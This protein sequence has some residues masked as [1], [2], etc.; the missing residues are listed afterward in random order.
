LDYQAQ[1]N[2]QGHCRKVHHLL[3]TV[4]KTPRS[5]NGPSTKFASSSWISPI[6]EHSYGYVQ[7]TADP[8]EPENTPRGASRYLYL[9]NNQAIHLELVTQNN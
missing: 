2:G 4:Q 5:V 3:E 8:I 1:E 6:F 7:A 9:H